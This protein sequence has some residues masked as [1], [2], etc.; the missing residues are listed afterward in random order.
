MVGMLGLRYQPGVNAFST[1]QWDSE[2]LKVE[3]E[4]AADAVVHLPIRQKWL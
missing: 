1:I 3:G 4:P 2:A